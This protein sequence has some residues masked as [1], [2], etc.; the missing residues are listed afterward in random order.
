MERHGGCFR[1][2]LVLLLQQPV[3]TCS[4]FAYDPNVAIAGYCQLNN[5]Y[6]LA[7]QA[8]PTTYIGK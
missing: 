3:R 4:W 8:E 2:R 1:C 5:P 7:I 6:M